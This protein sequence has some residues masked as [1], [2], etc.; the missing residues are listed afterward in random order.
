MAKA[1]FIQNMWIELLGVM[2]LSSYLKRKGH[3]CDIVIGEKKAI[4]KK[5]KEFKPDFLAFSSMTIQHNWVLDITKYLR[6]IGIAIPIIIGGPHATFFPH[7]IE[8]PQIDILCRGE[9]EE[10]LVELLGFSDKNLDYSNIKNLWVKRENRIYKNEIRELWRDLDTLAFPDRQLYAKYPYFNDKPYE[11]F[12]ATRGCPFACNFCFNHA[13]R[14]IYKDKG[15]FTRSRSVKNLIEEIIS[16]RK[17]RN[18]KMVMFTDSTFNLDKKWFLEFAR[19]YKNNVNIPYSCNL[20]A[21]L[22]DEDIARAISETNCANVRIAIETGN[23]RLR[24]EILNKQLSDE[25]IKNA[26]N[27]LKKYKIKVIIFNMFG[28]PTETL[29]NAFE[30]IKINQDLTP[31]AVSNDIFLP[32]PGLKV[33]EYAIEKGIIKQNDIEKLG[34]SPYKMFISILN[35]PE[36]KQVCN[37]HKFSFIAMCIPWTLVFIRL[38]IRL[39]RNY[40]FNFIYGISHSY[41]FKKWSNSSWGRITKE[42]ILN[43]SKFS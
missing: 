27:V 35:Q 17:K 18:I 25:Q 10:A 39:P 12:M 29:K 34:K 16:V 31:Y 14:E 5:I 7:I 36:I 24:R 8:S 38:L 20:Y 9:G 30:T 43:F 40:I 22:I 37:L 13:E 19:E 4:V 41:T 11:I 23:E 2:T 42:I 1:L 21:S 32:L 33:T 15:K 28:L 26:I 3:N 6:D